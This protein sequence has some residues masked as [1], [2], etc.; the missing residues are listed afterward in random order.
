M[1]SRERRPVAFS[2]P[3]NS[4][5]NHLAGHEKRTRGGGDE[6]FDPRPHSFKM[7][8][9][10]AEPM[11]ASVRSQ[12]LQEAGEAGRR[13]RLRLLDLFLW[14]RHVA[15]QASKGDGCFFLIQSEDRRRP[16]AGPASP[17]AEVTYASTGDGG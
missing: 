8:D 14:L 16:P 4:V 10:P 5:A 17:S 9:V 2:D 1:R 3:S 11:S 12:R 13:Q 15:P 7:G 6:K